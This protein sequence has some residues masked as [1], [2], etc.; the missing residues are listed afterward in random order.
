MS[1]R[2]VPYA[3]LSYD[4]AEIQAVTDVLRS[5]PEA[6][7]IGKNVQAMEER[8]AALFGKRFG[9]AASSGSAALFLAV[10]MLDLQ[11]G[12]EVV[13]SPLTF[14]TDLAP[15]IRAG[16]VCVFVDVEP[17]TF[18]IDVDAIEVAITDRTKGLLVPNLGGNAPDWDRLR[19]IA[20]AHSLI[21]IEDS[22]DALGSTLR[23]TP[24][25]TR[26]DISVTSFSL[27]HIL[28]TAGQ[29][30][31]I[32]VDDEGLRDR[33][34]TLRGWGRRSETQLYGSKNTRNLWA[35]LDGVSYDSTFIFDEVGWN[36]LPN[37][38]NAAFGVQQLDK[39]DDYRERRRA[40]CARYV[41]CMAKHPELFVLPR[42]TDGLDTVW[43][44]FCFLIQP[45]AGF[46][47]SDLQEFLEARGIDTR[48]VWTGN[49]ARQPMMKNAAYRVPPTGLP[50]ADLAMSHGMSLPCGHG[51]E[52]ADMGHVVSCLE[53]FASRS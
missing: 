11:P 25:G 48:V 7:R 52:P 30:G 34:L 24:T 50:N 35:D 37:E 33:C 41:E 8:V 40:N 18:Q 39:L 2:R 28:T 27:A 29:G 32:L 23:G 36:F 22:C 14:S 12:D 21:L 3:T 26:S 38:L 49:A 16:G 53:E 17:D 15:V 6:L 5:G 46:A 31:M 20:D 9:V 42:I 1:Y 45:D 44:S 4:E 43:L 19:A 47:R 51:L 10:D 13:T